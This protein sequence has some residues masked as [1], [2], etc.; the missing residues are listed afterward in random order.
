MNSQRV[1]KA[2]TGEEVNDFKLKKYSYINHLKCLSI[3]NYQLL[4]LYLN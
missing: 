2:A 3:R 4:Y 1:S